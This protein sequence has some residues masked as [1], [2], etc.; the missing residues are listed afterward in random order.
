MPWWRD[1]FVSTVTC[2]AGS[3][4]RVNRFA[5]SFNFS[6]ANS[7]SCSGSHWKTFSLPSSCRIAV[8][9]CEKSGTKKDNCCANPR[10]DLTPVRFVGLGKHINALILSGS[11]RTPSSPTMYPANYRLFQISNFY[12]DSVMFNF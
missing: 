9:A 11:G 1:A 5:A 3:K 7:C 8:V 10:N 12:L 4:C 2:L 6:L